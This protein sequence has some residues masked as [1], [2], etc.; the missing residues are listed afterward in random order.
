[1]KI[2]INPDKD[3]AEE[4]RRKIEENG[5]YCLCSPFRNKDT[6]CI[7]KR[8]LESKELGECACGLYIKEEI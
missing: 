6:K 7:C 2:K 3:L 5:G 8:F 4:I 1:M